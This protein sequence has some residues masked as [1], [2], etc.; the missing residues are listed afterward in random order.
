MPLNPLTFNPLINQSIG[1]GQAQYNMGR[2][3][4]GGGTVPSFKGT[5]A[6]AGLAGFAQNALTGFNQGQK[7]AL[8]REKM[9][10]AEAR[11]AAA[12]SRADRSLDLQIAS[13][14][15]AQEKHE[16]DMAK[17][18]RTAEADAAFYEKFYGKTEQEVQKSQADRAYESK[19]KVSA[20]KEQTE[21][22]VVGEPNITP[23]DKPNDYSIEGPDG[24]P[25]T[26]AHLEKKR[27][28]EAA[29]LEAEK[30][31]MAPLSPEVAKKAKM[32][33]DRLL[34]Q[35]Q[36]YE[37]SDAYKRGERE[38]HADRYNMTGSERGE[39]ISNGKIG[40]KT[41]ERMAQDREFAQQFVGIVSQNNEDIATLKEISDI[42]EKNPNAVGYSAVMNKF[43]WTD[44]GQIRTHLLQV[45]ARA[46]F[47][48][49][50]ALKKRGISLAPI[51]EQELETAA[52]SVFNINPASKPAEF[53]KAL[54]KYVGY[55]NKINKMARYEYDMGLYRTGSIKKKP[56]MPGLEEALSATAS[57]P[58]GKAKVGEFK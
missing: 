45:K 2:I 57:K 50:D 40:A 43:G 41:L 14:E 47:A 18:E 36:S 38:I 13:G 53:E 20:P 16:A 31:A 4:N 56:K 8:E 28:L 35:S 1:G 17:M 54:N 5:G 42:M 12:S 44:P 10:A 30:T 29:V 11:A 48:G 49:L 3:G 21:S 24:K 25:K 58:P 32:R 39:Y 9:K 15:R 51:T 37:K 27:Q 34:A 23:G 6:G 55:L 19:V 7:M 52:Q 22:N 33:Y 46:A 26:Y